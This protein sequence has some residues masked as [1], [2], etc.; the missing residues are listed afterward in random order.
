MTKNDVDTTAIEPI[1]ERPINP[2]TLAIDKTAEPV[3]MSYIATQMGISGPRVPAESLVGQTFVILGAKAYQSSFADDRRVYFCV[4]KDEH[5]GE[6]FTTSLGGAAVVDILDSL[7]AA[8]INRPVR[9]TLANN[10]GGKYGHYYT[11]E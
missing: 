3:D 9:G 2:F 8:G 5:T 11:F 4:C 6:I 10:E 7:A 1:S